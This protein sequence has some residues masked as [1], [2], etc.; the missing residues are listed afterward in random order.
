MSMLAFAMGLQN[1][2]VASTT[3]L[4]VRTT[5]LTG[6]ATDLGI[7]LGTAFFASGSERRDSLKGAALRI[8]KIVAFVTGAG[9]A[10]PLAD[11]L[12]YLMLLAPAALVSF[13][14]VLSFLPDW[15]PSDFTFQRP[16]AE[17]P[18]INQNK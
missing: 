6:P 2:A 3:G 17:G 1:A 10:L 16:L 7:H 5:H 18:K 11:R 12:G 9:V 13:A 14:V 4:S 15:S 8:G